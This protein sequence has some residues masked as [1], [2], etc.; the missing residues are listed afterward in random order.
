MEVR[1]AGKLYQAEKIQIVDANTNQH[2]PKDV[3]RF[4][5]QDGSAKVIPLE[6]PVAI[7]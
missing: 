6:F 2:E 5:F 3:I 1:V 7:S 4:M